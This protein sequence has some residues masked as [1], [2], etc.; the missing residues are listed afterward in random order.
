[1]GINS[2]YSTEEWKLYG[3]R[4]RYLKHCFL[5]AFSV[6][7][8]ACFLS[9]VY[10][11]EG[12][13]EFQLAG[14]TF[15]FDS[16]I[17]IL[18]SGIV[19]FVPAMVSFLIVFVSSV[20][21][22]I[23]RSYTVFVY[24][25]AAILSFAASRRGVYKKE[26]WQLYLLPVLLA[27]VLGDVQLVLEGLASG[28]GF[29][30]V[31]Y[32]NI[33]RNYL[34]E[35]PE[36]LLAVFL[37]Y[38]FF[39]YCSEPIRSLTYEGLFYRDGG[40]EVDDL[41]YQLRTSR[42][43]RAM[44]V[45]I[46]GEALVLGIAAAGFANAL[47][48]SVSE[49]A[50]SEGE[51][52]ALK[53]LLS[54]DENG[55]FQIDD[56]ED[57]TVADSSDSAA[58]SDSTGDT[59][60]SDG[61]DAS[62]QENTDDS[63]ADDENRDRRRRFV[64]NRSGIAFDI[65]LIMV[66]LNTA[67]PIIVI[68]NVFAQ[69]RIVKPIV[70]M[71][72]SMSRFC[73]VPQ[74]EKEAE[75]ANIKSLPIHSFDE[76]GDMYHALNQMA[77]N[78]TSFVDEEREKD[79]LKAELTVAQKTS[80]NKSNFLSSVSHELRTPINAVLGL[81][82]MIIRESG[83]ENIIEYATEIQ[84]A[85]KSLLGLVNDILDTSKLEEGKMDLIPAEYELS[86]TIND[87]IN[88]IAVKA[89]DK[90][91]AFDINVNKDTPH[92]LFGD[93]VRIKQ[94]ILNILTNAVKYTEHGSVTM[95]IDFEKA[96]DSSIYLN[97]AVTDT[98]IGIRAED[99]GRLFARF[100]R[101]EERR[102]VN[103]EGSGLGMNIV[104]QILA[105]MGSE[106]E[107]ESEYGK[108][109]NFHFS[110]LQKVTS[111]DGIGDFAE[112]YKESVASAE[113]YAVSFV[114]PDAR[115]LV[116]D[117]T[118]L[119]LTVVKGLLKDTLISIITASSG[120]EALDLVSKEHFDLIFMDQ[121]MPQM[122]GVETF[123]VMEKMSEA[124]ENMS[125]GSPVIALTAN[126]ISGSRESFLSEGFTDYLS[127]PIDSKKLEEIVRKY[128]PREL[129]MSPED[130]SVPEYMEAYGENDGQ[131][132]ILKGLASI[133]YDEAIRNCGS[134]KL[135]M[136]VVSDYLEVIPDRSKEVSGYFENKDYKNYTVLVH[137]MKSSSRLIGAMQLSE[138]AA[139]L[140]ACGEKAQKGDAEA[141]R[142]IEEKTPPMIKL[143]RSYYDK[144]TPLLSGENDKDMRPLIDDAK[145]S[146]ALM[147]IRE[148][149]EAFDF[150][151]ADG[152]MTMLS[153][154][155]MPEDEEERVSRIRRTLSAVDRESL[156]GL[157]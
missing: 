50:F 82:E 5:V 2:E 53:D 77:S 16:I 32:V 150:D 30:M 54:F 10:L 108:G 59:A 69:R 7:F 157:L 65:K 107:V 9:G 87:L 22:D 115:I 111:W 55:I 123:H 8:V 64:L 63:S 137:A 45:I 95:N 19:G 42:L 75:L 56:E 97:V 90:G 1:M 135:L 33:C 39:N 41:M 27:F 74:S 3:S 48:P 60:V 118:P 72:R 92:M 103:I 43:S 155:R 141:I 49:D 67:I 86:S 4:K 34:G 62:S 125:E 26:S 151:S 138:D 36:S 100:E 31:N 40:S 134:E 11:C 98:G 23:E 84:N 152:V 13:L 126:A 144:L 132:G 83:E 66:L 104:Q 47:L 21:I 25:I 73:E 29:T 61:A 124:G 35:F 147:A 18:I 70:L 113:S 133:D 52:S 148:F 142:E 15:H 6:V 145:L 106:L 91:L 38:L 114:A 76:I 105:L 129:I 94:V 146:E 78:I 130:V 102:N 58:D 120:S 79:R 112:A 153:D 24:L 117:D 101:I 88:M 85:G 154:Y 149:V 99:M 119:N 51:G 12:V 136:Q 110:V 131:A 46:V 128:L 44:M 116:V 121:R 156:L 80:E 93:E 37:C 14:I 68:G 28:H 109:S 81:D 89:E 127:K 139:Y 122:D 140:E 143:Y 17:V 57:D 96:D 20:I 71:S